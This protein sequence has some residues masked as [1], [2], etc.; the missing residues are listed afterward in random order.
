MTPDPHTLS[1]IEGK[2]YPWL[3]DVELIDDWL[4]QIDDN[5]YDQII[6]ALR[7]LAEVGPGLGRPLVDT[8]VASRHKNMKERG[9]DQRG[10]ARFE[11]CSRSTRAD[12]RSCCWP[13]TNK[14]AGRSGT[15]STSRS[16]ISDTTTT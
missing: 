12:E 8:V 5:S 4:K 11:S 9:P 16:P 1:S 10:A 6:A 2:G 13:E 15:G 7:I 14:G 3:V